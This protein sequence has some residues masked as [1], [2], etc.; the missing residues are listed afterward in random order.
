MNHYSKFSKLLIYDIDETLV[1]YNGFQKIII[2]QIIKII[3]MHICSNRDQ[4][5][6]ILQ[7]LL[8]YRNSNVHIYVYIQYFVFISSHI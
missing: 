2:L 8:I 1:F 5:N 3:I 6:I 4:E 7:K